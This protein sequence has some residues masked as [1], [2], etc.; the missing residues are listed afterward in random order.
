MNPSSLSI[1]LHQVQIPNSDK[2]LKQKP[3]SGETPIL[4]AN[5]R[6]KR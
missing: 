6:E 1:A 2:I 3:S 4:A 5:P